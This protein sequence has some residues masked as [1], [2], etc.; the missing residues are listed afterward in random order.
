MSNS[1]T[2]NQN[3]FTTIQDLLPSSHV[4]VTIDK[5]RDKLNPLRVSQRPFLVCF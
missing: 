3:I 2:G 4:Y 5:K 1:Y